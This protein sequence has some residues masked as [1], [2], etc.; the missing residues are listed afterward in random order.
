M[1]SEEVKDIASKIGH[2]YLQK[3]NGDYA[4]AEKEITDTRF[5]KIE[6]TTDNTLSITA[7]RPGLLIGK[8]GTNID[9]LSKY[10]R[11]EIKIIE[12]MDDLHVWLIPE[13][14]WEETEKL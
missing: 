9:A 14:P 2:Y 1:L 3:L 8:K 13:P 12:E 7:G 4:L 11:M 10:L 5:T 6:V